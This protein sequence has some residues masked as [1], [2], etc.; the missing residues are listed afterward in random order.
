MMNKTFLKWLGSAEAQ[1]QKKKTLVIQFFWGK[2]DETIEQAATL[3]HQRKLT[4]V[5]RIG[6][7]VIPALMR[8]DIAPLFEAFPWVKAELLEY[9]REIQPEPRLSTEVETYLQEI[10]SLL[11]QP[12]GQPKQLSVPQAELP[13]FDD[14]DD[15]V[16][17]VTKDNSVDI[18]ANFLSS[19]MSLKKQG[20][21]KKHPD[22]TA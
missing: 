14:E 18:A 1:K 11:V 6:L 9:M 7:K 19:V 3:V 20:A 21:V 10:K 22:S 16:L 12:V 17:E 15:L 13:N 8:G 2:E 5:I 4:E